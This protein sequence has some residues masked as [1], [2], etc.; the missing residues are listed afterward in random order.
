VERKPDITTVIVQGVWNGGD[1][2]ITIPAQVL[3]AAVRTTPLSWS[4]NGFVWDDAAVVMSTIDGSI[5]HDS[6]CAD[7]YV[8]SIRLDA[9]PLPIVRYDAATQTIH[10]DGGDGAH[11]TVHDIRGAIVHRSRLSG[12]QAV[13]Q[14]LLPARGV[15]VVTVE[16]DGYVLTLLIG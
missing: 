14:G 9:R 16:S 10:V 1:T 3:L 15:Y 2:V 4:A 12:T 5:T 7:R 13:L 11:L 6:T 8:R